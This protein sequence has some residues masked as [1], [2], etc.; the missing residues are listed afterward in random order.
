MTIAKDPLKDLELLIHSRY[1]IIF[2]DTAEE[3]RADTLFKHLA[4]HLKLPFFSW[5]ATKGL[6]REDIKGA[7]Y[8]SAD[9]STTLMHIEHSEFVAIY[10]FSGIA[11]YLE[12]KLIV[13]KLKDSAMQFSKNDGVIIIT[14]LD[15]NIPDSLKP[16]SAKLNLPAPEME[17]YR[18]L[19][20]RI[21]RDLHIRMNVKVEITLEDMNKI[22]NNMK[23]LLLWKRKRFLPES[24]S[25]T[26]SFPRRISGG[27]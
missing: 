7:V 20:Q 12:D 6:R 19:L 5:T 8:K 2:V 24:L 3:D 27:L 22:L 1:C 26:V 10:H 23:A 25:K 16:M 9:L 17:E 13:A 21:I 18:N 11:D 15:I 14:G 4:D